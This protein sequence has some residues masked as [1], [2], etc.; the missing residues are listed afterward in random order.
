VSGRLAGKIAIVT[1]STRGIGRG[2]AEMFAAE[3]ARVVVTGRSREAGNEVKSAIT[4]A[5][6]EAI[7]V[8]TDVGREEDIAAMV[9]V[10]L[11]AYGRLDILV[12]N[13]APT[14]LVGPGREDRAADALSTESWE[15][16]LRVA[17]TG[18]F[19]SCK[20][21]LPA[22]I[23]GG[24]GAI[25]NISSGASVL[26]VAGIDAYT[27]AKGGINALTRSLAVE[28]AP[29]GIRANCL[30]LGMVL[31]S[32]GAVAMAEDPV[33]GPAIRSIH[34]T[35]LGVPADVAY[36]A[37]YLCSDE[38]AFVTGAALAVDGGVTCKLAVPNLSEAAVKLDK[39]G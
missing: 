5:G 15:R 18:V 11:A 3:G 12:N 34:L 1:G 25:L 19:W 7:Y 6:G 39:R 10:T 4:G 22:M 29:R 14:E 16:I 33:L 28:Y 38:A 37:T 8:P 9:A 26:G 36:A 23:A 30:V 2:I 13:A 31:T 27:A 20:H 35:R 17:L 32:P 24:G 21:A